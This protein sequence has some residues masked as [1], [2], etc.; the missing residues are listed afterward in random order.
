YDGLP[1]PSNLEIL[2][3]RRP[4]K[5]IVRQNIGLETASKKLCSVILLLALVAA[6]CSNASGWNE[7]G[8]WLIACIAYD[9]MSAELR[10]E[11]VKTIRSH[12]RFQQDFLEAMPRSVRAADKAT[13]DKWIFLRAAVWPDVA[14]GFDDDGKRRF[15]RSRWHYVNRPV[16]L[17]AADRVLLAGAGDQALSL[18]ADYDEHDLNV[19][20]AF[21]RSVAIFRDRRNS[22]RQRA[23]HLCWILHLAGDMHQ[24][25]HAGSLFTPGRFRESDR[26]GN[27]IPVGPEQSLHGLWDGLLGKDKT[28]QE[29]SAAAFRLA[30]D[31]R[32][33]RCVRAA[34]RELDWKKW[35]AESQRL[36]DENVYNDAIRDTVSQFERKRDDSLPLIKLSDDYLAN[37]RRLAKNQVLL[38][39][40][41]L[42]GVLEQAD[43]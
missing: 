12:E 22:P 20:Q 18:P 25:L 2:G 31:A 13:E 17:S 35:L 26:G 37:A 40:L 33:Q 8:H 7:T 15:H 42:K 32:R 9:S 28:T 1:R 23:I 5:A 16:F 3:K 41:R 36:A 30:H 19:A 24:P 6:P 39:G 11:L 43:D 34:S 10:S 14:R 4:W 29:V 21:E 38:G 27:L